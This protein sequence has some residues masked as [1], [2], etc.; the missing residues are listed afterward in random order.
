[1]LAS[2]SDDI[3]GDLLQLRTRQGVTE[4]EIGREKRQRNSNLHLGGQLD[5]RLLG[6]FANS[7]EHWQIIA[8]AWTTRGFDLIHQ[9]IDDPLV[10]IVPAQSR[11]PVGREYL[12]DS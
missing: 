11:V 9:E 8:H 12:K 1:M 3:A 2:A 5:L 4:T 7:G 10:E 6:R